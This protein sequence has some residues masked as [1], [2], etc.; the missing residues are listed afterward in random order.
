LIVPYCTVP[1]T[2]WH[3]LSERRGV[4]H[5]PVKLGILL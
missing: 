5:M 3:H 1:E 2:E 4:G